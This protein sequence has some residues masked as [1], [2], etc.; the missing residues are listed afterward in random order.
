MATP[1]DPRSR[2]LDE[3]ASALVDGSLDADEAARAAADPEVGTR[4]DE[5]RRLQASLRDVPAAPPTAEDA[6]VAAAV[7]AFD[8]GAVRK[9]VAPIASAGGGARWLSPR[10]P[11]PWLVAAAVLAIVVVAAG[12]F[13]RRDSSD[14][15]VAA[16]GRDAAEEPASEAAE[17]IAPSD[18][19]DAAALDAAEDSAR[20]EVAPPTSSSQG[21][22]AENPLADVEDLGDVDGVDELTTR[23]IAGW[24]D[25]R[26]A[27]ESSQEAFEPT[28]GCPALSVRGDRERGTSIYVAKARLEGQHVTVHLYRNEGVEGLRLVATNDACEDLVDE[29]VSP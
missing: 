10:N 11:R 23:V 25:D 26:A 13:T 16:T 1:R 29:A 8:E 9:D 17:S 12:L 27:A 22:S 6:A 2:D 5:I 28:R 15:N 4:A 7:D 14:D 3:L 21:T 20:D 19:D 18:Q 24:R